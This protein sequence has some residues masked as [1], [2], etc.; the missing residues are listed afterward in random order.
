MIKIKQ[1]LKKVLQIVVQS[2]SA[3]TNESQ[4]TATNE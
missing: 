3:A 1:G 4:S 2:Q